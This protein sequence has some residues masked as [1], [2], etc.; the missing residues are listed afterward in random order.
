MIRAGE[1]GIERQIARAVC[2]AVKRD[3]GIGSAARNIFI[4][5]LANARFKLCQIARQ[6]DH[7][8]ALLSVHRV[9]FDNKFGSG[10]IALRAT[11]SSHAP[12]ISMRKVIAEKCSTIN[13]PRPRLRRSKRPTGCS[14]CAEKLTWQDSEDWSAASGPNQKSELRSTERIHLVHG[15][16]PVTC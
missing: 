7:N 13:P 11:I 5:R 10:V 15:G 8:V 6:I 12:H 16:R 14:C 2:A 3:G 4:D 1:L 9:E